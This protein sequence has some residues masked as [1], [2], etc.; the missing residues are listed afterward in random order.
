M[1]HS[2]YYDVNDS[3]IGSFMLIEEGKS[4]LKVSSQVHLVRPCKVSLAWHVK[5]LALAPLLW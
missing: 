3:D 5:V 1:L 4:E 2:T